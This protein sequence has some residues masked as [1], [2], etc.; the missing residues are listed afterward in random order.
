M[1]EERKAAW[2]PPIGTLITVAVMLFS[3]GVAYRDISARQ[4]AMVLLITD[5]RND[6]V[7]WQQRHE[8]DV[9]RRREVNALNAAKLVTAVERMESLS[10]TIHTDVDRNTFR[11]GALE[12]AK[13]RTDGLLDALQKSL[14]ELTNAVNLLRQQIEGQ[15][16]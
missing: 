9:E 15:K 14:N 10:R 16:P 7:D 6:R 11:I 4:D 1:T 5:E 12:A 2:F 8:A 3:V 13:P